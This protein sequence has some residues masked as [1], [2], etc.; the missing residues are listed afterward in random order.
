MDNGDGEAGVDATGVNVRVYAERASLK[1]YTRSRDNSVSPSVL[2]RTS[3]CCKERRIRSVERVVLVEG[4][5]EDDTS[6]DEGAVSEPF[7]SENFLDAFAMLS[8]RRW[9]ALGVR[10]EA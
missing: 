5:V 1:V 3:L 8:W 10:L 6:S 4:S 2:K 7:G 9:D